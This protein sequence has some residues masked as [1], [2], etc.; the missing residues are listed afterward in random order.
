MRELLRPEQWPQ[1]TELEIVKNYYNGSSYCWIPGDDY[2]V[3]NIFLKVS[4]FR[5]EVISKK[6]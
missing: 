3:G 2:W 6:K 5:V 1:T 4:I